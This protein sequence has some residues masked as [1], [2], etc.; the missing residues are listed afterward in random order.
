MPSRLFLAP[1]VAA[2]AIFGASPGWAAGGVSLIEQGTPRNAVASAGHAAFADDAS[3]SFFNPA[4]MA[5]LERS[6]FMMG[7]QIV[8]NRARFDIEGV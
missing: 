8:K 7:T 4:G 1:L 5:R 2:T 6:Q 3:T